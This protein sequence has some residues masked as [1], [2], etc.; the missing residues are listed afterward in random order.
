VARKFFDG[1]VAE[2]TFLT[3]VGWTFYGGRTLLEACASLRK[4]NGREQPSIRRSRESDREFSQ[5]EA[6]E[7]DRIRQP[8]IRT[9]SLHVRATARKPS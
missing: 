1:V 6:D 3:D 4:N 8:R 2:A 7:S 9:H 5:R